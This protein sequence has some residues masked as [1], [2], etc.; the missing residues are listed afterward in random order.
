MIGVK[1]AFDPVLPVPVQGRAGPAR[2]GLCAACPGQVNNSERARRVSG[3]EEYIITHDVPGN[4]SDRDI[5]Q[6]V[7]AAKFLVELDDEDL[8]GALQGLPGLEPVHRI[9]NLQEHDRPST[10]WF[11]CVPRHRNERLTGARRLCDKNGHPSGLEGWPSDV[12]ISIR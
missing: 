4:G 8:T 12:T 3:G 11:I 6:D 10:H 5:K 1:P 7:P 9:W 2:V